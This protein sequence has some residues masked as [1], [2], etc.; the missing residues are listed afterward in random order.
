MLYEKRK[1]CLTLENNMSGIRPERTFK[2]MYNNL[3]KDSLLNIETRSFNTIF[4]MPFLRFRQT[5]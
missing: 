1:T 2:Y 5:F 3:Y 4:F